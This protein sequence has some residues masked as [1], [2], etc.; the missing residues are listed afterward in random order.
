MSPQSARQKS[1]ENKFRPLVLIILDGVGIAP[2]TEGNAV[3]KAP[4]P[5]LE[6]IWDAYPHTSLQAS[7]QHVGLPPGV[8]GNSEVG[9]TNLGAGRII[10][11]PL[12]RIDKAIQTGTFYRNRSLLKAFK[13]A[14]DHKSKLHAAVC[15][16][17]AGTHGT[18]AHLEALME[19]AVKEEF[20]QP[21]VIHAF[22]DGRDA[23]PTSASQYFERIDRAIEKH[24]SQAKTRI[25][26][27]TIMGRYYAM[28]RNE[29]WDRTQKAYDAL[30]QGKT[31][32]VKNWQDALDI[33]YKR[34]ETDEFIKP[35]IVKNDEFDSTIQD[36]DSFIFLN[37]R[38]DRALQLTSALIQPK[39][40]FDK[41]PREKI[42]DKL[43]FVGMTEYA[44][45]F[46]SHVAFPKENLTMPFGRIIAEHGLRQ[47]RIAESEKFPH[48]TYFFNGGRSIKFDGE[49][50]IEVPSPSVATYDEKPEMSLFEV[51]EIVL[52]KIALKIYDFILINFANGDMVG[53][54]GSLE[55][56]I[57]AM[58]AVDKC[59]E[60]ITQATKS[61]GGACIITADH[62]N[63]EELLNLETGDMDTEHSINKV[64][65]V[66]LPPARLTTKQVLQTGILGD[67]AP[68]ML[69]MM[70]VDRPSEMTG[71]NL[72]S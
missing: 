21:L 63:V 12:P 70:G 14:K 48:V 64:P 16:S 66:F 69:G 31:E 24:N 46:P 39:D 61:V 51:T 71:K 55:A 25:G 15:F 3:T 57:K 28:D 26:Y 1:D 58:Q 67:V 34:E 60:I 68:T 22:T 11:Q 62:G 33:T 32:E 54:T 72:M 23:P 41:F 9:H 37:F 45:D 36:K 13:H 17:D 47:L 10:Y 49:D 4:T 59:A 2:A 56:S 5:F 53:H 44:K 38:A 20:K 52:E 18:I 6:K 7:Q 40:E 8:K 35:F 43:F 29:T 19:L 27:G 30:T 42:I 50:R 65:F